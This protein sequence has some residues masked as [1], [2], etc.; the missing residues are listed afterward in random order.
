MKFSTRN[1]LPINRVPLSIASILE[2]NAV[3]EEF[4]VYNQYLETLNGDNKK[5]EIFKRELYVE[6]DLLYNVDLSLYNSVIHLIASHL[7]ITSAYEAFKIATS[8]CTIVLNLPSKLLKQIPIQNKNFATWGDRVNAMIDNG[9]LGF[10]LFNMLYN[11]SRERTD[12]EEYSAELFLQRNNLPAKAD[13]EAIVLEE[14]DGIYQKA[15]K[16]VH[17]NE[18]FSQQ[19]EI[20][21]ELFLKRGL[22]GTGK[23]IKELIKALEYVPFIITKDAAIPCKTNLVEVLNSDT[24]LKNIDID[25]WYHLSNELSINMEEFY[26]I[27]GL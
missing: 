27:R 8:M 23:P 18:F 5:K 12:G 4:E 10:M 7:K 20:G 24:P 2:V 21:K 17:L 15:A 13:V 25:Q 26:Q 6:R 9:E 3:W 22:D 19:L 16:E 11:Y 14:F 1:H